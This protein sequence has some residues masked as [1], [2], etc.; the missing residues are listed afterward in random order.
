MSWFRVCLQNLQDKMR[1][2]ASFSSF[3]V[4]FMRSLTCVQE[5]HTHVQ[6]SFLFVSLSMFPGQM[7]QEQDLNRPC[8]RQKQQHE[9]DQTAALA[10]VLAL[11]HDV[12]S[13]VCSFVA[14]NPLWLFATW[15][16]VC[17]KADRPRPTAPPFALD[18]C[19]IN[20]PVPTTVWQEWKELTR[21]T[22]PDGPVI[23]GQ[24][25]EALAE[26]RTRVH[27][28][29]VDMMRDSD[30][31]GAARVIGLCSLVRSL[32]M[33]DRDSDH[34][35]YVTDAGLARFVTHL[36]ESGLRDLQQLDLFGCRRLTDAGLIH[37]SRLGNLQH[38]DLGGCSQLTDAGLVHLS[39]LR[40]LQ[41]LDLRACQHLTDEGLIPLSGLRSLQHL[42]LGGCNQLT[43]A[44][45]IRLSRLRSLQ[46]LNLGGCNQLTNAGLIRLSRLRSLQHLDLGGCSQLTPAG[47]PMERLHR[48]KHLKVGHW[49]YQKGSFASY[50]AEPPCECPYIMSMLC[51]H[52]AMTF[53]CKYFRR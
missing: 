46:H 29:A 48:L 5:L 10:P 12:W 38:L 41:Y 6:S 35:A 50:L 25:F 39:G 27:E 52:A 37:L 9:S 11:S 8:K 33:L 26:N 42:N 23:R 31:A 32:D 44:G 34:A 47:L 49:I 15:R 51:Q 16:R 1:Y 28:I 30:L 45:L 2:A 43:N 17:K 20:G 40:N 7:Q 19:K 18:L 24:M 53:S 36:S 14:D 13:V 21:L 4:I 3:R 22:C